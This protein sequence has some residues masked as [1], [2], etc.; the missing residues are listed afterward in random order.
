MR[1][2][3]RSCAMDTPRR[4][5][6]DTAAESGRAELPPTATGLEAELAE[7]ERLSLDDLRLRWRNNW[8][9]LAPAHLSRGLLHRDAAPTNDLGRGVRNGRND[10]AAARAQD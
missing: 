3:L 7:L 2:T 1:Q 6:P 8:G 5:L 4:P 9:R 10:C